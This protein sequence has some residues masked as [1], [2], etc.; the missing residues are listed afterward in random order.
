MSSEIQVFNSEEFG[1]LRVVDYNGES[2]FVAK[3][4]AQ[5]LG[6]SNPQEATRVH[7]KKVNKITQHSETLRRVKNPP[8]S[9]LII[10]ESDVYRL[11]MRSNLPDAERFQDWVCDEVLPSIHK[12]GVYAVESVLND[13]DM[14]IN[15]LQALKA[16]RAARIEAERTKAQIGS[17]REATAMAT[18]SIACKKVKALE[19]ELGLSGDY[20][21]VKAIP[22]LGNIFD[23]RKKAVYSLIGKHLTTISKTSSYE[24]KSISDSSYG[25]INLYHKDVI[26]SFYVRVLQDTTVLAKYRKEQQHD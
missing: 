8:V 12:H 24:V 10:P 22:W 14:L 3:D 1:S 25:T 11:I 20:R 23:L 18:A 15:A 17:K 19:S 16:E 6:Y 9:L 26:L 21:A 7:C 5:A 13:P 4:V 2:W